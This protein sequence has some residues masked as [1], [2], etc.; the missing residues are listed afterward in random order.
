MIR[1]GAGCACPNVVDVDNKR[2]HQKGIFF[3]V[4]ACDA[5]ERVSNHGSKM[6]ETVAVVVLGEH[7]I[8]VLV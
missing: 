1:V 8:S 2:M 4:G 7:R 5:V 3:T 6:V